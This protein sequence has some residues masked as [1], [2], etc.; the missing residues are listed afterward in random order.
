MAWKNPAEG[1]RVHDE[2]T[3]VRPL[4]LLHMPGTTV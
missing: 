4:I 1:G 2:V 3:L